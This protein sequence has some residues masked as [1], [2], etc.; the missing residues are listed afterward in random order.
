MPP[1]SFVVQVK[2]MGKTWP[3][4]YIPDPAHFAIDAFVSFC[5]GVLLAVLVSAEAQAFAATF[6]GDHRVEAKDRF[7]FIAFFHLDILGTINYLVGGFGWAK[8]IEINSSNFSYPRLFTFLT[9]L[10]GP[11]ANLLMAGIAGSLVSILQS[12]QLFDVR[13]FNMIVAV[14]ITTAVYNLIPLPP[15]AAGVLLTCFIPERFG[16]LR[17]LINQAGPFLILALTLF[18]RLY[19]LYFFRPWLDPLVINIFRFISGA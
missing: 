4:P 3:V 16:G 10:A 8:P 2:K 11:L 13:V 6:L 18:D 17:R 5:L 1:A 19:P 14:N 9:R 12:L 7:H 15:L